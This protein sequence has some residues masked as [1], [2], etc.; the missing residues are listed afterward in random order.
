MCKIPHSH[1]LAV[2][3]GSW[4]EADLKLFRVLQ[5][6]PTLQLLWFRL[7]RVWGMGLKRGESKSEMVKRKGA[8]AASLP[9]F[10]PGVS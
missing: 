2:N 3:V 10:S 1:G 4:L 9:V 5:F 8:E 7:L 6:S